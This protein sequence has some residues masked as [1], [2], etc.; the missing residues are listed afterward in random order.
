MVVSDERNLWA[1][2]LNSRKKTLLV[3]SNRGI[4]SF[5]VHE[6]QTIYYREIGSQWV[7]S[8]SKK[9]QNLTQSRQWDP[10]AVRVDSIT[11]NVYVLDG[12]AGKLNIY[13]PKGFGFGIAVSDL[14][15]PVDMVLDSQRGIM[16][17]VQKF[18][19]VII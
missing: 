3:S 11:E 12:F 7:N 10:T 15:R 13:D 17:I 2:D 19:S 6:K 8:L 5:D 18:H 16:F 14:I 4:A 9:Y 1:L